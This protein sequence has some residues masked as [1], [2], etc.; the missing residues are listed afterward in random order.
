M[1]QG[2]RAPHI[3]FSN[4]IWSITNSDLRAT[5]YSYLFRS[6]TGYIRHIASGILEGIVDQ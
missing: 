3:G 5:V 4:S 6:D 1:Q 2:V